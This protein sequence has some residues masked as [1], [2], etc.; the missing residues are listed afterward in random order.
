MLG[1]LITLIVLAIVSAIGAL[2]T[3]LLL[4]LIARIAARDTEPTYGKAWT[5]MFYAHFVGSIVQ[6][7]VERSLAPQLDAASLAAVGAVFGLITLVFAIGHGLKAS[8][9]RAILLSLLM[10]FVLWAFGFGVFERAQ[11]VLDRGD[12]QPVPAAVD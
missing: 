12:G 8:V 11:N 7:A 5:A 3:G 2:L 10:S 9:D 1:F 4:W 6:L